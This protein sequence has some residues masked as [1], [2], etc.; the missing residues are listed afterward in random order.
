MDDLRRAERPITIVPHAA[1]PHG[2]SVRNALVRAVP[3]RA[4]LVPHLALVAA[5]DPFNIRTHRAYRRLATFAGHRG[6][7][8]RGA[9]RGMRRPKEW[10]GHPH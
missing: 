7:R 1:N 6:V 9:P 3:R 5:L 8:R 4:V 10:A 2:M